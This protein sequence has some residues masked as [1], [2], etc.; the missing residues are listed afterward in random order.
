L[1]T[2]NLLR[3]FFKDNEKK[4]KGSKAGKVEAS[5]GFLIT[6]I[7]RLTGDRT[8]AGGSSPVPTTTNLKAR[9]TAEITIQRL[10][11]R[12]TWPESNDE[13]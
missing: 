3:Y 10:G 12:F 11:M 1:V 2:T 5:S 7:A 9:S 13:G 8:K 4:L 6:R